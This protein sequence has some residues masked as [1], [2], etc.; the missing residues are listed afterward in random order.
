MKSKDELIARARRYAEEVRLDMRYERSDGVYGGFW[1]ANDKTD[2]GRIKARAAA[3]LDFLRQYAGEDSQWFQR[4]KWVYDDHGGRESTESGARQIGDVLES[5][6]DS[7][8]E[9]YSSIVGADAMG[10]RAMA[11]TDLME[12]VRA[13][14]ADK[15]VNPAAPIVLAGAALEV[16]LR[17]AVE[18]RGFTVNGP[19]S[20]GA[21]AK[22]LRSADVI[23]KQDMK[24]VEAMAG[25]RNA[26]AHGDHDELSRER[27]GLMEQQVNLFLARLSSLLGD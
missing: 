17:G 5:W 16:A 14:V 26:A 3:A 1:A 10:V 8:E 15:H 22:A 9:G 21:Y 18:E 13:L 2:L 27:A 4:A 11:S 24:D 20:I 7:V 25:L 19:G 12:Q 23:S 6:A